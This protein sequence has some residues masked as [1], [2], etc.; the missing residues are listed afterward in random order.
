[1]AKTPMQNDKKI[2]WEDVSSDEGNDTFSPR[3]LAKSK[4]ST[5]SDAEQSKRIS[6]GLKS[7][8]KDPTPSSDEDQA[9]GI[10][11]A[12]MPSKPAA[13]RQ[14]MASAQADAALKKINDESGVTK[15]KAA[16]DRGAGTG[17]KKGGTVK[18][19]TKCMAKGGLTS[20]RGD[21]IASKGKTKC[22]Y[23]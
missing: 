10:K 6:A 4:S 11:K 5:M 12:L 22:K 20:S 23:V 16:W 1:M 3:D 19:K 7:F 18:A 2:K 13:S 21:G 14:K 17:L 15:S 8:R 9:R